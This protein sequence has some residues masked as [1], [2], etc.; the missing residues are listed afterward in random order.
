VVDPTNRFV[1]YWSG[2]LRSTDGVTWELGAGQL[3]LDAWSTGT[4]PGASG[5]AGATVDPRA[6][7]AP[8]VGPTGRSASLVTGQV[9]DFRVKFD[10]EGIRLAVWVGEQRGESVGRLR[11]AVIDPATGTITAAE[12][13]PGAPALR[14][15]SI[16]VNRLAWVS[17]PG[18][19][20]QESSL[21]VLGWTG[22]DFG[23]IQTEP[24][25]N[26]LILR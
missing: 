14:R 23:E 17:P 13:L 8:A 11:L 21:Q 1:A 9:A 12:P 16:D 5:A 10:P 19:D 20:G 2:L 15:F 26:L 22:N 7:A 18:Q 25:Q 3:V 4:G 6:T 24:A